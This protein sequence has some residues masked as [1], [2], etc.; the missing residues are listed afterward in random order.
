LFTTLQLCSRGIAMSSPS[1]F[2][3]V[4]L[5]VRPSVKRVNCDKTKENSAHIGQNP[6]PTKFKMA[7]GGHIVTCK[8]LNR[9]LSDSAKSW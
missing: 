2:P 1:V 3:S 4:R 7:D 5:S 9:G 8:W 6:H